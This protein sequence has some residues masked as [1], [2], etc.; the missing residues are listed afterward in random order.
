[1]NKPK[2][3]LNLKSDLKKTVKSDIHSAKLGN[4][5]N[6]KV[7][8]AQTKFDSKADRKINSI[9]L[10]Q[11]LKGAAVDAKRSGLKINPEKAK[12]IDDAFSNAKDINQAL[13][14]LKAKGYLSQKE[15]SKLMGD[16]SFKKLMRNP[17]VAQEVIKAMGMI[18][19]AKIAFA[20][21][22]S[23]DDDSD[24]VEVNV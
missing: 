5:A 14:T 18:G 22:G 4:K 12:A 11:K 8:K 1:M 23:P 15:I 24:N 3:K 21:N 19:F 9:E 2:T 20:G 7:R 6:F 16:P 13:T 10:K 17:A